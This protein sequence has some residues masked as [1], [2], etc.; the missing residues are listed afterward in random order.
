MTKRLAMA[1]SAVFLI[2]GT[3]FSAASCT[4]DVAE[5]RQECLRDAGGTRDRLRD[6]NAAYRDDLAECH[7]Y[8]REPVITHRMSPPPA[9]REPPPPPHR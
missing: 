5:A 7:R 1:M 4:G 8:E 9:H 3:Q 6:C 2:A